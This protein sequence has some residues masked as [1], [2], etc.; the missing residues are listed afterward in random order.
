MEIITIE[1]DIKVFYLTAE[2]F[3]D[4]IMDTYQQLHS[5]ITVSNDERMYF[6]ISQPNPQGTIIY[7]AAAEELEPGEAEK[8]GCERFTIK[9]GKYICIDIKNH[10]SDAASIG[11][12][13]QKLIA[14]PGIDQKGY[15]LE[16]YRNYTDPDVR[17][18]VGLE[19]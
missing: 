12:A 7:K 6:G 18:M 2:S 8:Y 10:M 3:P 15:C 14:Q 9:K 19:R 5:L 1:K 17:C 11:I 13:F 4:K 16:C